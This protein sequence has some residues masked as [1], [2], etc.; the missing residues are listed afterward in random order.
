MFSINFALDIA[1]QWDDIQCEDTETSRLCKRAC[2]RVVIGEETDPDPDPES[3]SPVETSSNDS[4][5]VVYGVLA[6]LFF[7]S[8]VVALVMLKIRTNTLRKV[9]RDQLISLGFIL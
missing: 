4:N 3:P 7:V 6:V 9:V 8:F 5:F 2:T 1:G